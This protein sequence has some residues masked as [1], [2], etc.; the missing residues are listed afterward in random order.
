M[1][2]FEKSMRF[3]K[4]YWLRIYLKTSVKTSFEKINTQSGNSWDE[5]KKIA[6]W[7]LCTGCKW[8]CRLSNY[9]GSSHSFWYPVAILVIS[10]SSVMIIT[11]RGFYFKLF[12]FSLIFSVLR[13]LRG[14]IYNLI[15]NGIQFLSPTSVQ[16]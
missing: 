8:R 4:K 3:L 13:G 12:L 16:L 14:N 6:F 9:S 7:S 11:A 10:S 1:I 5:D 15:A 2:C